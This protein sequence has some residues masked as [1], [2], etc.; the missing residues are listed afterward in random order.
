MKTKQKK[1]DYFRIRVFFV[2]I[3]I[4]ILAALEMVYFSVSMMESD[5]GA[6]EYKALGLEHGDFL[7][8]AVARHAH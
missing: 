5:L 8:L 1:V 2:C 7:R 6:T 4:N 3:M